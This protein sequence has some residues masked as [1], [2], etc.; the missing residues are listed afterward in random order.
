MDST[1][2][3]HTLIKHLTDTETKHIEMHL[4]A[5]DDNL[6]A[7]LYYLYK[8]LD[9]PNE[10]FL[11]LRWQLLNKKHKLSLKS[12]ENTKTR[13]KTTL[14]YLIQ[15][16][17]INMLGG[18]AELQINICE[19]LIQK[20]LFHE[21]YKILNE[22]LINSHPLT[23]PLFKIQIIQKLIWLLPICN[24]SHFLENQKHLKLELEKALAEFN[25][26]YKIYF[27]N[28]Q[29]AEI[30][31]TNGILKT[32]VAIAQ[33]NILLSDALH[34]NEIEHLPHL[35]ATFLTKAN[36]QLAHLEGNSQKQFTLQK[37]LCSI[38]RIHYQSYLHSEAY[39]N[40][41]AEQINLAI[42]SAQHGS[43]DIMDN[44]LAHVREITLKDRKINSIF[45]AQADLAESLYYYYADDKIKLASILIKCD[46]GFNKI[47][48]YAPPTVSEGFRYGLMKCWLALE[49]YNK[50]NE[51]YLDK[52][53][54]KPFVKLDSYFIIFLIQLCAIYEQMK[55]N[56][57]NQTVFLPNDYL[58]KAHDFSSMYSLSKKILPIEYSIH[59]MFITLG[60]E[61]KKL[62]HIQ[63]LTSL[64][65]K[66]SR[67]EKNNV[68]YYQQFK[69]MFNLNSWL[70]KMISRLTQINQ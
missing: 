18:E 10:E 24:Q 60:K 53:K 50:V 15:Q 20:Q 33:L 9:Q 1:T 12:L 29:V 23:P 59:T 69:K 52:P 38:M 8:E 44:T 11:R 7:S 56:H 62:K 17:H 25:T 36:V 66:L 28:L 26:F 6:S 5:G 55:V 21:G 58:K 16:C 46:V 37:L 42:L 57:D 32:D 49:E 30:I 41:M 2:L 31:I 65:R 45:K 40:Y 70:T 61:Q 34:K 14:L 19:I 67:L 27:Y 68:V 39:I 43:K 13:L 35:H 4:G 54:N 48:K 22:F 51:W 3:L 63:L 47:V 64:N